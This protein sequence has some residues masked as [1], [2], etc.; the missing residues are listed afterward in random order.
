MI[1][2]LSLSLFIIIIQSFSLLIGR[3]EK[4]LAAGLRLP[5]VL[6]YIPRDQANHSGAIEL[7]CDDKLETE[8]AIQR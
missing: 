8:I 6:S 4:V 1:P 3:E 7:Y 5:V 2:D